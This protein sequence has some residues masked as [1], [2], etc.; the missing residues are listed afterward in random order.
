MVFIFL[1][2]FFLYIYKAGS[3]AISFSSYLH[4]QAIEDSSFKSANVQLAVLS[5][6]VN[7][8]FPAINKMRAK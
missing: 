1:K 5:S 8:A 4:P 3:E 6:R 7:L 2:M